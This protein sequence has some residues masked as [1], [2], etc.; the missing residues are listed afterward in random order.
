MFAYRLSFIPS[1]GINLI[2][3]KPN[4]I[5]FITIIQPVKKLSLVYVRILHLYIS[6]LLRFRLYIDVFTLEISVMLVYIFDE[7]S[8]DFLIAVLA[9]IL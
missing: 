1:F 7:C 2:K 4:S 3:L 6:E 9:V 5:S 8:N